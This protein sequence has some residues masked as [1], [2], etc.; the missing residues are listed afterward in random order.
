MSDAPKSALELA[1]ERLKKKDADAGVEQKPLTEEQR[2]AIAEARNLYEA[3]VAERRIMH[4]SQTAAV[5]DPQELELQR[6]QMLR[7]LAHFESDRD[8]KI[9]KIR[10]GS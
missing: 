3:R 10:E 6:E 2:E 9:R 5:F 4:Q 1:L 7:D 8:A